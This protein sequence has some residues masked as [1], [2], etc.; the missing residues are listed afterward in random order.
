MSETRLWVT[1]NIL[2]S[3]LFMLDWWSGGLPYD[4]WREARRRGEGSREKWRERRERWGWRYAWAP[5]PV[6]FRSVLKDYPFIST[7]ILV[8]VV[9]QREA[10]SALSHRDLQTLWGPSVPG[11]K[12]LSGLTDNAFR[13]LRLR[14]DVWRPYSNSCQRPDCTN[15]TLHTIGLQ[16]LQM[17]V[18]LCVKFVIICY[19][20]YN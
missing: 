10:S 18:C 15:K 9:T 19:I 7:H 17:C 12:C 4:W 11:P 6:C 20:Y 3:T 8:S 13:D 5:E 16:K 1:T 14:R 2:A